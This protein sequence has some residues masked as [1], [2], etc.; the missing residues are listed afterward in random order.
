MI[1]CGYMPSLDK[2]THLCKKKNFFFGFCMQ[3]SKMLHIII[4]IKSQNV[5][6]L[7]LSY[8]SILAL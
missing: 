2:T 3:E 6:N 7:I 5:T 4:N 1:V 8:L